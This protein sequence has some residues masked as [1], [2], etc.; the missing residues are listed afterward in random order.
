MADE[1]RSIAAA[2]SALD[3]DVQR[4]ATDATLHAT[5]CNVD[6]T[7]QRSSTARPQTSTERSRKHRAAKAMQREAVSCNVSLL[8]LS[9]KIED[10][11][12]E[13][14]D[15]SSVASAGMHPL[16]EDWQPSAR[17]R[18]AAVQKLGE[19]GVG[20]LIVK[21][22]NHFHARGHELR[23]AAGWQGRFTNW[24]ISEHSV[25]TTPRFP[26]MRLETR[27]DDRWEALR[28]EVH[29]ARRESG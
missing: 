13:A 19:I 8:P 1:M 22:C 26:L 5:P 2:M 11:K 10:P 21:F 20:N 4:D 6:A 12:K 16:P 27:P 28:R 3:G 17:S 18:R 23:T 29:V 25:V 14:S 9:P 15:V 7:L 24:V